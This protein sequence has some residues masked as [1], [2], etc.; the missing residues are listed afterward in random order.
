[1]FVFRNIILCQTISGIYELT[2]QFLSNLFWQMVVF[3]SNWHVDFIAECC[4]SL[5]GLILADFVVAVMIIVWRTSTSKNS[6]LT[7][8]A[9]L[10]MVHFRCYMRVS[11]KQNGW[12]WT[13]TSCS[14]GLSWWFLF[15]ELALQ[16][17]AKQA[18]SG[19]QRQNSKNILPFN[20]VI[21]KQLGSKVDRTHFSY[22][23]QL[24]KSAV[25][26]CM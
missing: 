2:K 5:W 9:K 12:F 25:R 11:V 19:H 7:P 15:L 6:N 23:A 3:K 8:T 1:M 22:Q 26:Y 10:F 20:K 21:A 4:I 17:L 18:V 16:P 24:L 13:C 14:P